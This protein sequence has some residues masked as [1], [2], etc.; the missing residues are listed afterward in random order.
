V[1]Y[2]YPGGVGVPRRDGSGY[3]YG[4]ITAV[5]YPSGTDMEDF[6][7]RGYGYGYY[8]VSAGN[9]FAGMD[10]D[11]PYPSPVGHMTCG[12]RSY[13]PSQPVAQSHASMTNQRMHMRQ[14]LGPYE[15]RL[16]V[17]RPTANSQQQK[18]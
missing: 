15:L 2:P 8:I 10:I 12:P 16:S 5:I 6:R 3:G 9:N 7:I 1:R 17:N 13:S 4:Q 11:Y 14:P 18:C